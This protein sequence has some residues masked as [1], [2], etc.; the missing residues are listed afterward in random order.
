MMSK[1]MVTLNLHENDTDGDYDNH[2]IDWHKQRQ[3]YVTGIYTA[4]LK[5]YVPIAFSSPKAQLEVVSLLVSNESPYFSH[6]NP[7]NV[8]FKFTTFWQL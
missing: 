3:M 8:S 1:V 4:R 6:Y 2:G 5:W 7:Q